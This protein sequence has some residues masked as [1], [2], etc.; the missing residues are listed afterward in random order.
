MIGEGVS[1]TRTSPLSCAAAVT[2]SITASWTLDLET[3]VANGAVAAAE[4][5]RGLGDATTDAGS[6]GKLDSMAVS[7]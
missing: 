1:A 5:V 6:G 4:V 7:G 3:I 2:V